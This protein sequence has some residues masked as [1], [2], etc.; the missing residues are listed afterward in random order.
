MLL[1][2]CAE[3]PPAE[4]RPVAAGDPQFVGSG[5][6]QRCHLAEY[7]D[8]QDSHHDLAMQVAD[9]SS[10]LGDFDDVALGYFESTTR[11]LRHGDRYIVRTHDADGEI[12]DFTVAYTYGVEPLQQYLVE[13]DRGHIQPLPFAWDSR[14]ADAGGQ[15]WYHL[16]PDE[17]IGPGDELFWTGRVQNWNFMC[18]ECHSTNVDLNYDVISDTYATTWSEIDV[19]CEACHGPGSVHI[20][21]AE[22]DAL[23]AGSA[24]PVDLADQ[25]DVVWRMNVQTGIA[26]RSRLAMRPPQQ[27]EA[28]GRCHSRRSPIVADYEYGRPLADT[29]R[30]SLLH[31]PLYF[32]D[33]QIRDEVYVYGSFLQSRMYQAGVTCSDCHDPHS[34][35]LHTGSDPDLVCAQCHLPTR[36]AS[37][38][39]HRHDPDDVGCVDCH[40]PSRVYMGVDARRDHR[41]R[42]P[43]PDLSASLGTPNACAD[44]HRDRDVTWLAERATGWW[45]SLGRDDAFV[46]GIMRATSLASLQPP[47]RPDDAAAIGRGLRDSDALVRMAAL[48]SATSL[49]PE[50]QIQ[51]AAPLLDDDV[52]GVRIEAA[53]TLA[54][55]SAYLPP[56]YASSFTRAADEFRASQLAIASRPQAHGAL[57]EFEGRLGDLERALMHSDQAVSMAPQDALLRHSRGLLLV[58]ADRDEEALAELREAAE[59]AP[60]VS[61]F[62][63]VYAVALDSNGHRSEAIRVVEEAIASRHAHDDQL[64]NYLQQLRA[65]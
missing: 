20:E 63:Y 43:R 8:W 44:C 32:S 11:F 58:R 39:H 62:V 65:N 48:Q 59:L 12:R 37:V 56:Q 55:L 33:G 45:G 6:C 57:A 46:P 1:A 18:A 22:A 50:S 52:R 61:R 19:G 64:Q 3:E 41:L 53:S 4:L 31:E 28:C 14:A 34:L 15:R 51:L 16:Y 47:L 5:A 2:A 21:L 17:Y 25:R 7:E 23:P 10:V 26:E 42:I 36:F 60:E 38:D 9:A 54:A 13:L 49:S 24:L 29:H 27:P 30:P 40:M 35:S